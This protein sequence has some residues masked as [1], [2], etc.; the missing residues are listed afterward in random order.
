MKELKVRLQHRYNEKD[1]WFR[2]NPILEAGEMGIESD[3]G[4]FKYG[5]G[6][7]PWARLDYAYGSGL[8]SKVFLGYDNEQP[9]INEEKVGDLTNPEKIFKLSNYKPEDHPGEIVIIPRR[10][11]FEEV[12][13]EQGEILTA[14]HTDILDTPYISLRKSGVWYWTIFADSKDKP[15]AS[16]LLGSFVLNASPLG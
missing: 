5:D 3:T 1:V 10:Y 12:K 11:T 7:T 14:A 16:S 8:T 13:N 2:I 15:I 4:K 9:G 6:R